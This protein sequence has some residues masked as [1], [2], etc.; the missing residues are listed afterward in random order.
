MSHRGADNVGVFLTLRELQTAPVRHAGL[1]EIGNGGK[2][3][4]SFKNEVWDEFPKV[5]FHRTEHPIVVAPAKAPLEARPGLRNC[6]KSM[7]GSLT[8]SRLTLSNGVQG[9][10]V[11][12][13]L[14]ST[15]AGT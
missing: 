3:S 13:T 4:A 6:C 8:A 10:C 7:G 1:E 9:L 2:E 12:G 5:D 11:Q 14:Q 15:Q